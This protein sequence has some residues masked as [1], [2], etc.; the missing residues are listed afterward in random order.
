M[1]GRDTID[2]YGW[3]CT[4]GAVRYEGFGRHGTV[5]WVRK[6][7]QREAYGIVVGVR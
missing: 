3:R 6:M 5:D 4:V 7:L 2:G 1:V